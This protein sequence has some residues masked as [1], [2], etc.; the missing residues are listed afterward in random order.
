M[1]GI[2]LILVG[3][4]IFRSLYI[5]WWIGILSI[6]NGFGCIVNGLQPYLYPHASLGFISITFFGEL[7]FMLRLLIRGRKIPEVAGT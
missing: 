6:V 4:L 2:P 3:H 5:P 1:F 7:I